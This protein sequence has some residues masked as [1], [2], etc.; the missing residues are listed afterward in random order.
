MK[1][2]VAAR[3]TCDRYPWTQL[4]RRRCEG[5]GKLLARHTP[6]VG[7]RQRPCERPL[8]REECKWWARA[9]RVRA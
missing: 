4:A 9:W 3:E 7:H 2:P 1:S 6:C 8:S 5:N